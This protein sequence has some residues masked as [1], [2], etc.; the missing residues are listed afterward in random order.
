VVGTVVVAGI[1]VVGVGMVVIGGIGGEICC[2]GDEVGE[3]D[4]VG[5]G[6]GGI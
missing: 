6:V 1:V 4:E 2:E 3:R 5:E